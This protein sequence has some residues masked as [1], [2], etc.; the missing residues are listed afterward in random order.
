ME[1]DQTQL[2]KVYPVVEAKAAA[3]QRR[4]DLLS[5]MALV[6]RIEALEPQSV[7]EALGKIRNALTGIEPF[8]V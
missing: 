2:G 3:A 6:D 5:F 7:S 1:V 8:Y 4:V